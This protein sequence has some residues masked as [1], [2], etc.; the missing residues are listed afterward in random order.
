MALFDQPMN[1][2]TARSGTPSRKGLIHDKPEARVALHT[3]I[4]AGTRMAVALAVF[5]AIGMTTPDAI[6]AG[7]VRLAGAVGWVLAWHGWATLALGATLF[8]AAM[9]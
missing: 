2:I 4:R 5:L 6:G 1:S 8:A 9:M 3:R 7:D